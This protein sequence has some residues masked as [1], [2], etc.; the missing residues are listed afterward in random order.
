MLV[1][2]VS[3]KPGKPTIL[4][5]V[6]GKPAIG[7]PG[8]PVRRWSFLSCSPFRNVLACG[9][10]RA[11]G[12][13]HRDRA[14]THNVASI[15]RPRGLRAGQAGGHRRGRRGRACVRGV[16]PLSTMIN[17][18]GIAKVPLDKAGLYK[19]EMVAVRLF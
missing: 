10:R 17:A 3:I 19:G 6:E 8:N 9:L 5:S 14:L 11:P 4:A 2:G 18:D 7:L 15:P 16:Q 13:I 12:P 1:H